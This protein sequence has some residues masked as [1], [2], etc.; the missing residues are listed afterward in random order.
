MCPDG[1]GGLHLI[2]EFSCALD[3]ERQ[4]PVVADENRAAT[5]APRNPGNFLVLCFQNL[6]C[7][8][9]IA[10]RNACDEL[11]AL[12]N[13]LVAALALLVN[14]DTMRAVHGSLA[15]LAM[16]CLAA[17]VNVRQYSKAASSRST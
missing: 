16:I 17:G 9:V 3:A 1:A 15:R 14:I 8:G 6:G 12:A 13:P 5:G 2:I 10:S 7:L 11:E 4:L